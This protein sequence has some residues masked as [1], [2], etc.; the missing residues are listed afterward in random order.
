MVFCPAV[1]VMVC[2]TL[3]ELEEMVLC[4]A[5]IVIVFYRF[6]ETEGNIDVCCS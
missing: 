4:A 3:G 2:Y 1:S 5:V 6:G